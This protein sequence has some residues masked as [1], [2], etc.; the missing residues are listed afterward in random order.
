[1][2][3]YDLFA[4][5][6]EVF[7]GNN[8]PCDIGCQKERLSEAIAAAKARFPER[9]Y[10]VIKGWIWV[11]LDVDQLERDQY[12]R[13]GLQPCFVR[14]EQVISDEAGRSNV[15]DGVRSTA[16]FEFHNNAVF[17][18]RHTSYILLGPGSRVRVSPEAL[19][20]LVEG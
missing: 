6:Y 1:M 20:Y 16:L 5:L 8:I 18:T 3:I 9:P 19:R 14:S 10:C 12:E 17:V 13:L 7:E 11:D 15:V 4:Q 2:D